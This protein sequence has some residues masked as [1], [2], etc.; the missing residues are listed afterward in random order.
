[1]NAISV[2]PRPCPT[3]PAHNKQKR[4]LNHSCL[5]LNYGNNEWATRTPT[6][7]IY[8]L[9]VSIIMSMIFSSFTSKFTNSLK[10]NSQEF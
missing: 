7:S 8:F 5:L 10:L 1:M 6:N 4:V 9:T 2:F 3:K